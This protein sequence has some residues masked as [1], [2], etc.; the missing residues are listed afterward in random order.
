MKNDLLKPV[1]V[2]K[3]I[4]PG[5]TVFFIGLLT[6]SKI[7]HSFNNIA[8]KERFIQSKA[9]RVIVES[10]EGV[11]RVKGLKLQNDLIFKYG[12][13]S[14]RQYSTEGGVPCLINRKTKT[15]SGQRLGMV[16]ARAIREEYSKRLTEVSVLAK[17]YGVSKTCIYE[18]LKNVR[19]KDPNYIYLNR[20]S[21]VR[22]ANYFLELQLN[23]F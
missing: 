11:E 12:L 22:R 1:F 17:I 8:H 4:E 21:I 2:F 14:T 9:A 18:V 16:N 13:L 23:V 3:D 7:N 19:Y 15:Y 10:F 5:G 20:K 6:R